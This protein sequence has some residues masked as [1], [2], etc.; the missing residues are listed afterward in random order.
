MVF[1]CKRFSGFLPSQERRDGGNG[2]GGHGFLRETVLWVPASAGTTGWG[3]RRGGRRRRTWFLRVNGF[4][5]S[6]LRRNDGRR[7]R[8]ETEDMVF[9]VKRFSGFLP[10][11]ERRDGGRRT[12]GRG[13]YG[14]ASVGPFGKFSRDWFNILA[15]P[16]VSM[17]GQRP[18]CW[19]GQSSFWV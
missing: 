19:E 2:D 6:C 10:P 14:Y 13:V 12:T 17:V 9:Y 16:V 3:E 7:R 1:T 18:C 4:L 5:G 8:T 15:A 11:Q